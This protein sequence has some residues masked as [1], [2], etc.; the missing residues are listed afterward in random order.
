MEKTKKTLLELIFPENADLNIGY[1]I[2]RLFFGFTFMWHGYQKL[3]G[4]IENFVGFA[5]SLHI[6]FAEIL[7][8]IAAW[9]EFFGGMLLVLGLFTR[10]SALFI[11]FVM[12]TALLTAHI[13]D[14]YTQKELPV[15]YLFTAIMFILKGAGSYSADYFIASRIKDKIIQKQ[16]NKSADRTT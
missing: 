11:M 14:N 10:F 15:A 12:T 5:R 13:G 3:S 4:G 6:P 7:G 1:F 9:S 8:P 2:M 16:L